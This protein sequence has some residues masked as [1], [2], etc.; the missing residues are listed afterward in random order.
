VSAYQG[1]AQYLIDEDDLLTAALTIHG[2]E[3]RHAAYVAV[4]NAGNPFPDAVNPTLT[5][6]DVL[7]IATPFIASAGA[8]GGA[9]PAATT[10]EATAAVEV[11]DFAFTPAEL[12]V[13]AGTT[14]TWT[15][16]GGQPHTATAEDGS[17][18]TGVLTTGERASHTF[19]E[20]GTYPYVCTLHENT[21]Q[22]VV[23]V[24]E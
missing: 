1:A 15:N 7:E 17:F 18:D 10:N 24:R 4:L 8:A 21:M 19:T 20:S 14:V 9:T 12:E 22:G 6:V 5:P 11:V 3:A 2:V 13:A 16:V 23:I